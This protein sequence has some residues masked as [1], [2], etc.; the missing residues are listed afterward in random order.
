M[1]RGSGGFRGVSKKSFTG[2]RW[3]LKSEKVQKGGGAPPYFARNKGILLSSNHNHSKPLLSRSLSNVF[4]VGVVV[5]A[6]FV[7]L[8]RVFFGVVLSSKPSCDE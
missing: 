8:R 4:G 1:R 6:L 3:I 2:L 7:S 5:F